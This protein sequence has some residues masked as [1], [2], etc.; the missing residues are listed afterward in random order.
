MIDSP[1]IALRILQVQADSLDESKLK[2]QAADSAVIPASPVGLDLRSFRLRNAQI[3]VDIP[4]SASNQ[5]LFLSDV[6]FTIK[7][8]HAPDGNLQQKQDEVRGEFALV[9]DH[10]DF[11]FSQRTPVQ[12]LDLSGILNAKFDL[13]AKSLQ[14]IKLD[15]FFVV[16]DVVASVPDVA[17]L[18]TGELRLPFRGEIKGNLL[19]LSGEL[20]LPHISFSV[21]G[22]HWAQM[23]V[24]VR[25]FLTRPTLYA[26]IQQSR[27]PIEQ[28]LRAAVK[29][30]PD[31]LL[32]D[33]YLHNP[34]AFLSLAGTEI[35]GTLPDSLGGKL[36]CSAKLHLRH[37][38]VTLNR[39]EQLLQ[40]LNFTSTA[41]F[42]L[43]LDAVHNPRIKATIEI[44]SLAASLPD[45]LK[46]FA[47]GARLTVDAKL[48]DEL[49]PSSVKVDFSVAN[50]LGATLKGNVDLGTEGSL[51]NLR[52]NA[53]FALADFSPANLAPSPLQTSVNLNADIILKGLDDIHTKVTI[54]TDSLHVNQ[55]T[56][57]M[58]LAPL[59]VN[60]VLKMAT[61][62][63]FKTFQLHSLKVLV[64]DFASLDAKASAQLGKAMGVEFSITRA[65][66]LH[67]ALLA[68]MPEELKSAL[69]GLHIAGST[70]LTASGDAALSPTDTTFHV[71]SSI[72]TKNFDVDYMRQFFTLNGVNLAIDAD[73]SSD[74]SGSLTFEL[75]IDSTKTSN[76][77]QSVFYNNRFK[78][79]ASIS[80]F[81]TITMDSGFFNLPDLKTNGRISG[82]GE[83]IG[84]TPKITAD[85]Q[86][87]QAAD[88]TIFI[89]RDIFYAGQNDLAVSLRAD[90][91]QAHVQANIK[92]GNLS[93]SLPNDIIVD[94]IN[95]DVSIEQ[96]FDIQNSLLISDGGVVKTPTGSLLDYNLYRDYYS[97]SQS[98]KSFVRI[99]KVS[100]AGYIIE[101]AIIEAYIGFGRVD[102][103]MMTLDL[104]GGNI[105]AVFSLAINPTDPLDSS[106]GLS[107]HFSGINSA[108]LLPDQR[109]DAEKSLVTAHAEIS[110]RG[111]DIARGIDLDGYFHIT[112]IESQVADNLLRS[113]DPEGKDSGIR[114]TRLLINRGFKP[115]LF[116]FE[117]RHGYSYPSVYF[118]QPWYFPVRLSGGGIDLGRIPIAFFLQQQ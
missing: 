6:S 54:V 14:L 63:Q 112:E 40:D 26:Q 76:M 29:V 7:D 35:T 52:G 36:E 68:Y 107:A 118:D 27:I 95:A 78:L 47:A 57:K 105:G 97:H 58:A 111:F 10:S 65:A 93:V 64:N 23:Q 9:C 84:T 24:R 102:V 56:T 25:N 41:H 106:Y 114:S 109:V 53:H 8:L 104:Y 13:V 32:P 38:G 101:N 49:L 11:A 94:R 33:I 61:N 59:K 5:H 22:V 103:P 50:L 69:A 51:N 66:V 15:G 42:S 83:L 28:L 89:T 98:R 30:L 96:G 75:V 74:K 21:D 48:S 67:E 108:L 73:V 71:R 16:S 85:I 79:A 62:Q 3:T 12:S 18:N 110:G 77:P 31:T 81:N 90:S 1:R 88:D 60:S 80:D 115:K 86:L 92:T 100:A 37:F 87:H 44:D 117:I 20:D 19:P 45:S 46:A 113:L 39:G 82:R 34:D 116:S 2:P 72:K 99:R 70:T 43:G 55:G 4:D 91:L 17:T